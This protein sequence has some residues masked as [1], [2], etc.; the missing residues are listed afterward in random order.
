[1]G[2]FKKNKS[3]KNERKQYK[4]S[5]KGR[6]VADIA[7]TRA[8][9]GNDIDFASSEAYKL[10]RTNLTFSMDSGEKGSI[11]GMTSSLAGEGKSLT[12]INLAISFA[13]MDKKVLL[14]EGDMRKPVLEKY[15]NV[16]A[17]KGL[18]N[19]L[20]GQ[21]RLK[22]VVFKS[23]KSQNLYYITSGAIPPN[24]AELLS[25]NHMTQLLEHMK[26][27]FDVIILDLPPVTA[28][29][30]ATIASKHT[31]GMILVVR[32]NYVEK[33]DLQEAIR[34]L[35]IAEAKILGL[36]YNVHD[37]GKGHYYKKGYKYYRGYKKYENY[38]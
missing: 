7:D 16:K 6:T 30:D 37:T 8:K 4:N 1:M 17:P 19:I 13:D 24:P 12:S 11:F 33:G 18:S 26:E 23:S 34:L 14:I 3:E 25:S 28:V 31:D 38:Q 9:V 27:Q 35:T 2:L 21:C 22:E 15:F 29:A 10:L 20:A 36:V 5:K 32:D